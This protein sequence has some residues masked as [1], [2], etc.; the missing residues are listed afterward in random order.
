M[1]FGLSHHLGHDVRGRS[2]D[3]AE[4]CLDPKS[5]NVITYSPIPGFYI[6]YD[7]SKAIQFH[8]TVVPNK[9]TISQ[10]GQTIVEAQNTSLTDAP[11][12]VSNFQT[13]GLNPVGVGPSM[14]PP[15]TIT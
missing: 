4:Y 14:S 3:E 13:T 8:D 9:L 1:R 12:D 5:T 10:A 7:Y 15:G 6:H 11:T 2:W